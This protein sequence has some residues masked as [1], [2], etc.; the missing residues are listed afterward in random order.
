M[1]AAK[2][3]D[4]SAT[5]ADTFHENGIAFDEENGVSAVAANNINANTGPTLASTSPTNGKSRMGWIV[6]GTAALLFIIGLSVGLTN[7]KNDNSNNKEV[8]A[9]AEQVGAI[10]T[11]PRSSD[12]LGG[13]FSSDDT[14][15]GTVREEG[16]LSNNPFIPETDVGDSA[17]MTW[18][19]Y[20]EAIAST[21]SSPT[22][23]SPTPARSGVPSTMPST[24]DPTK[25]P[26]G[27]PSRQPTFE[28]S[29]SPSKG[30]SL[31][32]TKSPTDEVR[33]TI[34]ELMEFFVI[35]FPLL[36]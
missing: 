35:S 16:T 24:S 6:G 12:D 2:Q 5:A 15:N 19:Q 26:S 30:P 33:P 22:T 29:N 13:I 21:T 34:L 18:P 32:P 31:E 3:A 14:D 10:A 28:P 8:A 27:S 20:E 36:H 7:N 25:S 4:I 11:E 1:S 17:M 9:N 23:L